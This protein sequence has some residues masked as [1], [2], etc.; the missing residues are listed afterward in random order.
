M[1][2][3]VLLSLQ[4]VVRASLPPTE[5][6]LLTLSLEFRAFL[7]LAYPRYGQ[8]EYP[9]P[10]EESSIHCVL[11]HGPGEDSLRVVRT[12]PQVRVPLLK[13]GSSP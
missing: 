10:S 1:P 6:G 3:T 8:W 7:F 2:V 11:P 9:G 13:C 4:P 12:F 5:G